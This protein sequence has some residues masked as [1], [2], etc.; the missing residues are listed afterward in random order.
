[1][2]VIAK[3]AVD[4]IAVLRQ[5]QPQ[6]EQQHV[7]AAFGGTANN[8]AQRQ[9]LRDDPAMHALPILG[10]RPGKHALHPLAGDLLAI[11]V[12]QPRAGKSEPSAF[13]P[14]ADIDQADAR[15]ELRDG[16]WVYVGAVGD[17]AGSR[18]ALPIV[19]ELTLS[20]RHQLCSK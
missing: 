2:G 1:G 15:K 7:I 3:D 10:A 16:E 6:P 19:V 9:A 14:A 4:L 18:G 8:T 17:A 11:D 20:L 5:R 12:V 13:E